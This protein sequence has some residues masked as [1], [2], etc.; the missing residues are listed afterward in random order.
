MNSLL[1]KDY[2]GMGNLIGTPQTYQTIHNSINKTKKINSVTKK[3]KKDYFLLLMS[4]C[5]SA[6]NIE[7]CYALGALPV[8]A[9]I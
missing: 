3:K 7:W 5:P 6:G 9:A 4:Y 1:N 2:L 8:I